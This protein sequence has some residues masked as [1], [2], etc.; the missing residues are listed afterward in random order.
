MRA[1]RK[2]TPRQRRGT[3]DFREQG[4]CKKRGEKAGMWGSRQLT[5]VKMGG[6]KDGS[7]GSTSDLVQV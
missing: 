4:L 2:Q 7:T 3:R 1:F 6:Q 5:L